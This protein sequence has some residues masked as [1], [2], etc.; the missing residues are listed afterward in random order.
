MVCSP[1]ARAEI[2]VRVRAAGLGPHVRAPTSREGCHD[3]RQE[4]GQLRECSA[5]R[6]HVACLSGCLS[7]W[8]SVSLCARKGAMTPVKNQG[9]FVSAL[10]V[11][12]VVCFSCCVWW[13]RR[14]CAVCLLC[15]SLA[16]GTTAAAT[17]LFVCY[18]VRLPSPLLLPPPP[19]CGLLAVCFGVIVSFFYTCASHTHNCAR[20]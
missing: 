1:C 8:R 7:G 9:S 13:C 12:C 20:W 2:F 10:P 18:V 19:V 4:P 16:T 14:C 15:G 5:R 6:L 3:A 17:V 11:A